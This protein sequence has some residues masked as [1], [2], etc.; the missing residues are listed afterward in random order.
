MLAIVKGGYNKQQG[1]LLEPTCGWRILISLMIPHDFA[2]CYHSS[3]RDLVVLFIHLL[4]TLVLWCAKIPSSGF[5]RNVTLHSELLLT[6]SSAC[7]DKRAKLI[8]CSFFL[9]FEHS[10]QSEF[11]LI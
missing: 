5:Q 8:R 9:R 6:A 11:I 3:M 10:R 2:S 4:A 1:S 7:H